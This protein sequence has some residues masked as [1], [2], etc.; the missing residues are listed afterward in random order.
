[1]LQSTTIWTSE[2]IQQSLEKIRMGIFSD[3]ECFYKRD[4]ELKAANILFKLNAE[5]LKEFNK[6]SVDIVYFVKNYC[7]F[8][9]DYGRILVNLRDFQKD[10]LD[11]LGE[12]VY[13]ED[14]QDFGPKVRN[15]I[16]M[17]SRQIGKCFF[18]GKIIVKNTKTG[19]KYK[20][21]IEDLYRIHNKNKFLSKQ[22]IIHKIK[23]FLYKLYHKLS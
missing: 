17:A 1:M 2:L 21:Y 7:R 15:Y 18:N 13:I 4:I 10:I 19:K 11:T 23:S 3:L 6:C 5:E 12:Q 14:L 20:I 8:L 16:L 9:T 22:Y